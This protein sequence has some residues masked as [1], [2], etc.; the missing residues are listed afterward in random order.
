MQSYFCN[1]P[2]ECESP[3]STNSA[4]EAPGSAPEKARASALSVPAA[5]F[6]LG[7]GAVWH[8]HKANFCRKRPQLL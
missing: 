2:G 4:T 8:R 7:V 6:R 3:A 5:V 1:V